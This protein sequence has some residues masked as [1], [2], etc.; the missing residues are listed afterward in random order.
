M[1]ETAD[2][3]AE[4]LDQEPESD[5]RQVELESRA[6]NMGWRPRD[7]WHG[8][9]E[10][11]LPA[12]DYIDRGERLLPLLQERNRAADQQITDLR[13]QVAQQ[14]E[15]LNSMLQAA[16]RA[17]QVGYRRAMQELAEKRTR[18]VEMG[19]TQAFAAV[20]Q[21]MRELGPEPQVPQAPPSPPPQPQA[22]ADPTITAWINRN[23]WFKSDQVANVAMIA[24]MQKAEREMP[25]LSV[26]EH[27]ME[28]EAVIRQRFPEHFAPT[29]NARRGN[30]STRQP[31]PQERRP[32]HIADDHF[33]E[34]EEEPEPV[35]QPPRRQVAAVAR[36]SDS[37]PPRRP[38][39]RSFEAMPGEVR[40]QYERQRRMLEGKGEPL[41]REEFARYFWEAEG[42]G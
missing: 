3:S 7:R 34:P 5:Q 28:A 21:A 8:D 33:E 18:A 17:E 12:E 20:E 30:G 32:L 35:P 27:L 13:Q 25:G 22:N 16:R 10:K 11:W 9:P 42:E 40:A 37:P 2:Q 38:N 1:S 41:T 24:A 26:A 15:T 19:D 29:T 39:P 14:G 6:R 36:S 23:P 31:E 4:P